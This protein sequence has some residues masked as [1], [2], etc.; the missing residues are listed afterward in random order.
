M[1]LVADMQLSLE[2]RV[3]ASEGVAAVDAIP[4][5][6]HRDRLLSFSTY[7]AYL[8]WDKRSRVRP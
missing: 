1:Q 2:R 3:E 8:A 6:D 4:R 7:E 5:P